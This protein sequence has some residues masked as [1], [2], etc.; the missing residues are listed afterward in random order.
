M[1]IKEKS[2]EFNRLI[3]CN[4]GLPAEWFKIPSFITLS[5]DLFETLS[6][7]NRFVIFLDPSEN[8][9]RH[10]ANF[11]EAEKDF[12]HRL[13]REVI[14]K[15]P[16]KQELFKTVV[17]ALNYRS[18]KL[19]GKVLS[20]K[21]SPDKL[22]REANVIIRSSYAYYSIACAILVFLFFQKIGFPAYQTKNYE[23]IYG[24]DFFDEFFFPVAF[25]FT[26]FEST[27]DLLLHESIENPL[28]IAKSFISFL[29]WRGSLRLLNIPFKFLI[30][31]GIKPAD[32]W[33]TL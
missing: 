6:S 1:I 30:N 22:F 20:E 16:F 31:L 8:Y 14:F 32:L 28:E 12:T 18:H 5:R 4:N 29:L 17:F 33:I 26:I 21:L 15:P 11:K 27:V 24:F 7:Q 25:T 9:K 13:F 23:E 2:K 3:L 10:Y 19:F